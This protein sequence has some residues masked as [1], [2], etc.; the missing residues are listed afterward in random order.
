MDKVNIIGLGKSGIAAAKLLRKHHQ[1][2]TIYDSSQ[3]AELEKVKQDLA[4]EDIVVKLGQ[5]PPLEGEEKAK[6]LVVSPGVP[7]DIPLLLS[8]RKQELKLLE[9]WSWHGVT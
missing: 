1:S 6:L 4:Q 5:N 9:K 7:W 8:A 3:S 2:V